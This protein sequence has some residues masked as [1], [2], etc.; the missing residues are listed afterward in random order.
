MVV[1]ILQPKTDFFLKKIIKRQIR[2]F[3][4]TR[5]DL[6]AKELRIFNAKSLE[7]LV[8][9]CLNN[10]VNLAILHGDA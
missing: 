4:P 10:G 7:D 6:F 2:N 5:A 3:G 8:K 9:P 1:T